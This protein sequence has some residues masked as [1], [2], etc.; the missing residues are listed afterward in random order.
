MTEPP[1]FPPLNTPTVAAVERPTSVTVI[2]ILGIVFGALGLICTPFA[3]LPYVTDFG[4][5]NPVVEMV[6]ETTWMLVWMIFSIV[7]GLLFSIIL[8][9]GSIGALRLKPWARL[10]L[11]GY[12]IASLFM[13]VI[14]VV[15]SLMMFM[16]L[17]RDSD[18]PAMAA[19]ATGGMIGA[20]CQ[21]C[22]S[23]VLQGAVLYVLTRPEV[24]RAFGVR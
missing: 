7:L 1:P 6:K 12:S 24:K 8:L 2:A 10:T 21:I 5:P 13:T 18:N 22:F 3:I 14:S 9:A 20:G 4:G 11:I 19:A 15:V 23:F 16:P 17:F